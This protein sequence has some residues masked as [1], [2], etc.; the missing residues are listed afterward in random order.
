MNFLRRA[1]NAF[2]KTGDQ[3]R[4]PAKGVSER[5]MLIFR[6][7]SEVIEAESLLKRAGVPVRVKGPPPE[8]RTGCD[9]AI[10]FP[11]IAELKVSQL[12]SEA[13]IEPIQTLALQDLLLEPVSLYQVK[14]F[15]DYLMVRAGDVR[16][17]PF[18]ADKLVDRTLDEAPEPRSLGHTL[19]GYALQLAYEELRR[20]CPG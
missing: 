14:D 4:R 9:L 13:R 18:L 10:E 19:C 3:V 5:G 12:L 2:R 11:L 7:T 8:V 17:V 16:D 20:Q 6:H 1:W 15:G